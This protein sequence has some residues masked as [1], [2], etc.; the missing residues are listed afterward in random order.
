MLLLLIKVPVNLKAW[1]DYCI[2][3]IAFNYMKR[4]D[5]TTTGSVE[6]LSASD[7]EDEYL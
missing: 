7:L 6:K 2:C 1:L 4:T 3:N 5:T